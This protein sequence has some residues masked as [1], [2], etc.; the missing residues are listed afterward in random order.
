MHKTN[1]R[2]SAALAALL[3]VGAAGCDSPSAPDAPATPAALTAFCARLEFLHPRTEAAVV[4]APEVDAVGGVQLRRWLLAGEPGAMWELYQAQ[5]KAPVGIVSALIEARGRPG[6][7]G[8]YPAHIGELT[9][10]RVV[11]NV[12]IVRVVPSAIAPRCANQDLP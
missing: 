2:R 4:M 12:E 5:A 6:P 11:Q 10:D 9:V 8:S 1:K 7:L 3:L